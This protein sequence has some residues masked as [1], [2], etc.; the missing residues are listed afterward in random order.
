MRP[1]SL[2]LVTFLFIAIVGCSSFDPH[3]T[4]RHA[5]TYLHIPIISRDE[6]RLF[7]EA[8]E[9]ALVLHSQLR[10]FDVANKSVE[11]RISQLKNES[12]QSVKPNRLTKARSLANVD[13]A[14]LDTH[15]VQFTKGAASLDSK[16]VTGLATVLLNNQFSTESKLGTE[17][18]FLVLQVATHNKTGLDSLNMRRL[19]RIREVFKAHNIPAERVKLKV[20]RVVNPS[21]ELT[22]EGNASRTIRLSLV[23]V[24][25]LQS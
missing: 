25:K 8:T 2:S 6:D 5:G 13:T 18:S 19:K 11:D 3:Q 20:I 7:R 14:L 4:G 1:L 12:A 9:R 16:A 22:T 10:A 17:R 21:G 24:G 15:A 23:R